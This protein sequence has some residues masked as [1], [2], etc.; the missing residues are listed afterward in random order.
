MLA[1]GHGVFLMLIIMIMKVKLIFE[2]KTCL[3]SLLVAMPSSIM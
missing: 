2:A 1:G 3:V